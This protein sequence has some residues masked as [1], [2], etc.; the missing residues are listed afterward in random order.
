MTFYFLDALQWTSWNPFWN[1]LISADESG[2]IRSWRQHK[3]GTWYSEMVNTFSNVAVKA[4]KWTKDGQ[5]LLIAYTNGTLVVLYL[6]GKCIWNRQYPFE[7]L[8]AQ[9]S[10]DQKL[11][12]VATKTNELQLLDAFGVSMV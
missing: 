7:I 12:I 4:L 1:K 8:T 2:A 11:I 10:P 3:D 9:W 6:D 5:K